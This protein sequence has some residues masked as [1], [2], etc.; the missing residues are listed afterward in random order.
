MYSIFLK[1]GE[2]KEDM[3]RQLTNI[4][5][6][7]SKAFADQKTME[8]YFKLSS[9]VTAV[10]EDLEEFQKTDK[11][12]LLG[13]EFR[14]HVCELEHLYHRYKDIPYTLDL[15]KRVWVECEEFKKDLN[16]LRKRISVF[17]YCSICYEPYNIC[18]EKDKDKCQFLE[19]NER[20]KLHEPKFTDTCSGCEYVSVDVKHH[21]NTGGCLKDKIKPEDIE[22]KDV[23]L[24]APQN[25]EGYTW[26]FRNVKT[27]AEIEAESIAIEKREKESKKKEEDENNALSSVSSEVPKPVG[28]LKGFD[29][30]PVVTLRKKWICGYCKKGPGSNDWGA[31]H[32]TCVFEGFDCDARAWENARFIK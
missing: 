2:H 18:R 7:R 28:G 24:R 19:S 10:G 8:Y 13:G 1:I 6:G 15:M 26:K 9:M 14:K 25:P 11:H 27:D 31:D 30:R 16:I 32:R 5:T 20:Y 29:V 4:Q 23:Q 3:K 12:M 17:S 21:I 22:I